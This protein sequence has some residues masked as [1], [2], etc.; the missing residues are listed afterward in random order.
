VRRNRNQLLPSS[1]SYSLWRQSPLF[2]CK[3]SS[4]RVKCRFSAHC[5]RHFTESDLF[6]N[7]RGAR[8]GVSRKSAKPASRL[9]L[10]AYRKAFLRSIR[11]TA[12]ARAKGGHTCKNSAIVVRVSELR[13]PLAAAPEVCS[14]SPAS[15]MD[16]DFESPSYNRWPWPLRGPERGK[17]VYFSNRLSNAIERSRGG[18][19]RRSRA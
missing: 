12:V 16:S 7:N 3:G 6:C 2:P 9:S 4:N 8:L 1:F 13:T 17:K 15:V 10:I 11:P 19:S 14:V 18:C 5:R